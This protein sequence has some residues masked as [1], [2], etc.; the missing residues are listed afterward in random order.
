MSGKDIAISEISLT[1][2]KCLKVSSAAHLLT[3]A[4]KDFHHVSSSLIER[5]LTW[6]LWTFTL[7]HSHFSPRSHMHSRNKAGW[8]SKKDISVMAK[9]R[10]SPTPQSSH[11]LPGLR[12]S[13]LHSRWFYLR[14]PN[15]FIRKIRRCWCPVPSALLTWS[16]KS[17]RPWNSLDPSYAWHYE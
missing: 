14:D 12:L 8:E 6:T 1:V 7:Q 17:K 13:L 3:E 5:L 2:R 4:R 10:H 11:G 15:D 9:H 16:E